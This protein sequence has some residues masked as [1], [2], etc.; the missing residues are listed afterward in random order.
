MIL[1]VR[2]DVFDELQNKYQNLWDETHPEEGLN[3]MLKDV[4]IESLNERVSTCYD[5]NKTVTER[6]IKEALAE[7]EEKLQIAPERTQKSDI[8]ND[9]PIR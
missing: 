9:D 4:F 6:I 1:L 7:I 8:N 2:K 5:T 3:K